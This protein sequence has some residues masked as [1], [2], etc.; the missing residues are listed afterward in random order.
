MYV[1]STMDRK[2]FNQQLGGQLFERKPSIRL[3]AVLSGISMF[4]NQKGHEI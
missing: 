4:Q 1:Y 3:L 2:P